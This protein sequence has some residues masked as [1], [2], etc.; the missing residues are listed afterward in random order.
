MF[1]VRLLAIPTVVVFDKDVLNHDA[2]LLK[3]AKNLQLISDGDYQR[4]RKNRD[5]I[6]KDREELLENIGWV[7]ANECF[8]DEVCN[9][10]YLGVIVQAIQDSD[11]EHNSNYIALTKYLTENNLSLDC[12][13]IS[14]FIKNK[15]RNDL[16]LPI[17][18][19]IADNVQKI[20]N[21][22]ECYAIAIKRASLIAIGGIVPDD[23]FELRACSIGFRSTIMKCIGTAGL[24]PTLR[25][26]QSKK[27]YKSL[28]ECIYDF[29]SSTEE[30]MDVR[31][32]IQDAIVCEIENI[33][34]PDIAAKLRSSLPR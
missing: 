9:N 23:Y 25:E 10:G 5:N 7:G 20:G 21:V 22:P 19:A 13:G 16:K 1:S 11:L 31:R 2:K 8:E 32:I 15:K 24:L 34:C 26:F 6:L 17:A 14:S 30:G 28:S 3:Q 18:H 12:N 33:G 29:L 4:C 27:A